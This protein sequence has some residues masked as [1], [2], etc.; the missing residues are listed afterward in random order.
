MR[1]GF[2][3]Y[4][5]WKL[6]TPYDEADEQE[7]QRLREERDI[8]RADEMRDRER[9]ERHERQREAEIERRMLYGTD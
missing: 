8:E 5:K 9:C 1:D 7:N 3:N 4:D 6:A 2:R